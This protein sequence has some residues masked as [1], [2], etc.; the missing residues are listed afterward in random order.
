MLHVAISVVMNWIV[1]NPLNL[2]VAVYMLVVLML[3]WIVVERS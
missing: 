3:G 1:R 2:A